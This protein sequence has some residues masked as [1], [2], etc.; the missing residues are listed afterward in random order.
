INALLI[1]E[2]ARAEGVPVLLSGTGG[3]DLFS[4]YRRHRALK[5]ERSWAWLPAA[6]RRGI[7]RAAGAAPA[8]GSAWARRARKAFAH[9]HLPAD[10][11]PVSYFWW[12]RESMRRDPSSRRTSPAP[13]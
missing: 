2:A 12:R 11:P 7:S 3:D 8:N 6:A 1:A 4:G 5:L 10:D 9:A 13:P